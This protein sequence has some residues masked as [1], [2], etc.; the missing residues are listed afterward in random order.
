M[1]K[2]YYQEN[3]YDVIVNFKNYYNKRRKG[4]E[5]GEALYP[6]NLLKYL[7]VRL[8][9]LQ[10]IINFALRLS[11]FNYL[12]AITFRY[13]FLER[14]NSYCFTFRNQKNLPL[15]EMK[16]VKVFLRYFSYEWSKRFQKSRIFYLLLLIIIFSL[17]FEIPFK[18]NRRRQEDS[19]GTFFNKESIFTLNLLV[20]LYF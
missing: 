17:I 4:G 11:N 19:Y 9:T 5:V 6:Q 7:L 2:F 1:R 12:I 16:I 20:V 14:K 8:F 10:N 15:K 3:F 13:F 18:G